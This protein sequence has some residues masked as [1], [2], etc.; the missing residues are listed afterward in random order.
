MPSLDLETELG[1]YVVADST[2]ALD[3]DLGQTISEEVQLLFTS[4]PFP[5]N[6][7][8]T[9]G[10]LTGEEYRRWFADLAPLF[11]PLLKPD[12]SV[13]IELGNAWKP[14]RP[15]QSVLHLKSLLGFLEHPES[16]YR[17]CQQFVCYNPA[18]LPAPA[19]WVTIERCRVTDSF[20]RLWWYSLTDK[21]KADNRKVLRPYSE[22]M[23]QLLERQEYNAGK[24]PSGHDV[25]EESFLTDNG[26]SIPHNF[27]EL[28]ALDPDR[29]VRLPN[30]FGLA[31]T[32]SGDH[33]MQRCREEEI[34]PH[35]ARM[36]LGLAAF[37]IA[38]LTDPGD[39]V[40]DPFAGSN[41]TGY[42]A[43]RLGRRWL[44]IEKDRTYLQQAQVR[45]EDPVL[46]EADSGAK[47]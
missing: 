10:N 29:E 2:E 1:R 41:T 45:M 37:F 5:L 13:V 40:V 19:Q 27:F 8:K 35:P 18:R 32:N 42:V 6:S 3:G 9:Y 36:P 23:K 33:Y 24:R 38:F 16:D 25:G 21:P 15:V 44:S 26:G 47:E 28:D 22:P 12:G 30:V 11:Q 46:K 14:G 17:L 34:E 4:P 20:T 7:K 31:N 39:L 43:E